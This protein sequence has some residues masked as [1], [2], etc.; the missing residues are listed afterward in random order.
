MASPVCCNM[1]RTLYVSCAALDAAHTD[2]RYALA[3]Y[4]GARVTGLKAPSM[5]ILYDLTGRPRSFSRRALHIT[6]ELEGAVLA[7][8]MNRSLPCALIAC[9][10]RKLPDA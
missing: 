5:S 6:L 3:R 1:S 2:N 10:R 8:E 9:E 7:R 4:S